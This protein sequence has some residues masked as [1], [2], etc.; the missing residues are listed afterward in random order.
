MSNPS[1]PG[2]RMRVLGVAFLCLPMIISSAMGGWQLGGSPDVE[3]N[4]SALIH[5]THSAGADQAGTSSTL[6]LKGSADPAVQTQPMVRATN[7]N[8][9]TPVFIR[10]E[11]AAWITVEDE[12]D[13]SSSTIRLNSRRKTQTNQQQAWLPRL[14]VSGEA[15]V[16]VMF[17]GQSTTAVLELQQGSG[18]MPPTT[19][20]SAVDHRGRL[21][22][23]LFFNTFDLTASHE[24]ITIPA[25]GEY[26]LTVKLLAEERTAF[27]KARFRSPIPL[28]YGNTVSKHEIATVPPGV[29]TQTVVG[30]RVALE[31]M[32]TTATVVGVDQ[33][34]I[35]VLGRPSNEMQRNRWPYVVAGVNLT[36]MTRE[37]RY[38]EGADLLRWQRRLGSS[39]APVTVDWSIIQPAPRSFNWAALSDTLHIHRQ[40]MVRPLITL[41]GVA[42]WN[43][44]LPTETSSTLVAWKGF[45]EKIV[46]KFG[47]K[48]WG[49]YCWNDPPK[50]FPDAS[51]YR[52]ALIA[53]A[54]GMQFSQG[55]KRDA[56]SLS[57]G[58]L[59]SWNEPY[60]SDLLTSDVASRISA[61]ALD[62]YPRDP[63]AS[64]EAN[65]FEETL[66]NAA[67][68][69]STR[70]LDQVG[71]WIS[72]T[73]WPTGPHGVSPKQQANYL[74]RA[75]ILALTHGI[76]RITW[77][78]LQ[79][80]MTLRAPDGWLRG[81]ATGLLD[82]H[83]VPT[84]AGVAYALMTYMA[85]GVT[86]PTVTRQGDARI[87]SFNL[88]L[89]SNKWPS[90]LYVA[91]TDSP[92]KVQTVQLDMKHGGGVYALDYLGAEIP[93][94]KVAGDAADSITGTYKLPVGYEPVY[95]WDAGLPQQK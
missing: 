34:R 91:W 32:P 57:V 5:L 25:A 74:V 66:K 16:P 33:S 80:G 24:Q 56:M 30:S 54:D 51:I 36:S 8:A 47:D 76:Q 72:G 81:G 45:A 53:T 52:K 77:D 83:Q 38:H 11:G 31:H 37:Q 59:S 95:I 62:L 65:Q 63:A 29:T 23:S 12:S 26:T 44:E 50:T 90:T 40:L 46:D 27:P 70:G 19:H 71:L 2:R 17:A 10:G 86:S 35:A 28:G 42:G 58:P 93:A 55:K 85:S 20:I 89:Q 67:N 68:L 22:L 84:Q 79:N 14:T 15:G 13:G 41:K 39:F 64:P 94:T 48:I 75:H 49:I 6:W 1:A 3:P 43:Q 7:G 69:L 87:T 21:V 60:L 82:E 78:G 61:V 9:Y 18:P 4:T 92:D 88:P 73:A